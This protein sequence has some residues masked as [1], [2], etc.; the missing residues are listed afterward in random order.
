MNELRLIEVANPMRGHRSSSLHSKERAEDAFYIF[1]TNCKH[2]Y[3]VVT[4]YAVKET[5]Q[6]F[7]ADEILQ[8]YIHATKTKITYHNGTR[9]EI[10]RD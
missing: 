9:V 2:E 4:M 1:C 5:Q 6:G 10:E 7:V 8:E 3:D